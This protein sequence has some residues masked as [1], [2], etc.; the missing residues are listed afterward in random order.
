MKKQ[1]LG[2]PLGTRPVIYILYNASWH[3]SPSQSNA[4]SLRDKKDYAFCQNRQNCLDSKLKNC[5]ETRFCKLQ[6]TLLSLQ[7]LE[8]L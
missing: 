8:S 1:F 4:K 6:K 7:A 5:G 2:I 3:V